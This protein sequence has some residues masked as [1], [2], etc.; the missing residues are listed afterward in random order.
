M[1]GMPAKLFVRSAQPKACGQ[2]FQYEAPLWALHNQLLWDLTSG[3]DMPSFEHTTLANSSFAPLFAWF[4]RHAPSLHAPPR[5]QRTAL[6][7]LRDGLDSN[8]TARFPEAEFGKCWLSV[9]NH[10]ASHTQKKLDSDSFPSSQSRCGCGPVAK[11]CW[12]AFFP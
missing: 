5:S 6:I 2:G 11:A 9:R 1:L 12:V 7:S 8:D 4:N 3:N 10:C